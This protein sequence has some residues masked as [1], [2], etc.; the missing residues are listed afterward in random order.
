MPQTCR[1]PTAATLSALFRPA[2]SNDCM[3]FA[4]T[5]CQH[6]KPTKYSSI[7]Y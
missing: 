1:L 3:M 4:A 2:S 7:T 6:A 5:I